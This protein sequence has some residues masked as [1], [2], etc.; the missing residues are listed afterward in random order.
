MEPTRKKT[1]NAKIS[2]PPNVIKT[3]SEKHGIEIPEYDEKA[4]QSYV[5]RISMGLSVGK[6]IFD[7]METL[8]SQEDG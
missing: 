5:G 3:M 4:H 7:Q 1:L 2:I 6:K 8:V